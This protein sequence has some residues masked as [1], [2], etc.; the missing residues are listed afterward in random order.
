MDGEMKTYLEGMRDEMRQGF[1]TVD[2]RFGTM[3]QRFEAMDQRL[4]DMREDLGGRID[5]LRRSV[6]GLAG[7]VELNTKAIDALVGETA[8]EDS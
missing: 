2:Q 6:Q 7:V 8:S 4:D 3:D 5:E 1:A